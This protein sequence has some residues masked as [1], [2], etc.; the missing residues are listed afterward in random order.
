[1]GKILVVDDH[2]ENRRLLATVLGSR[3]HVVIEAGEGAQGVAMV[4]D[5]RPDLVIFHTSSSLRDEAQELAARSGVTHVLEESGDPHLIVSVVEDV[6]ATDAPV[7]ALRPEDD[8]DGD[9]LRALNAKLAQK[10]REL[11]ATELALRQSERRFRS[12]T[13][14]SPV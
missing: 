1:M 10:V 13:E 8:V 3:G 9:R 7:P 2:P 6:L 4:R 11:E 14:A 12:L 5:Q